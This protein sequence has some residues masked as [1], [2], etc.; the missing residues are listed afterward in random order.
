[1][2]DTK[3]IE[4]E[5]TSQMGRVSGK[6]VEDGADSF[7]FSAYLRGDSLAFDPVGYGRKDHYSPDTAVGYRLE[8]AGLNL[9][10]GTDSVYLAGNV[11][12]FSPQRGEPSKP[13]VLAL[14]R[15][16]VEAP[17]DTKFSFDRVYPN[18]FRDVL[19][20]QFSLGAG[21][22]VGMA[23]VSMT[24]QQVYLRP[25]QRLQPGSYAYR[26]QLPAGLAP[27]SYLLQVSVDGKLHSYKLLHM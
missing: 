23:V 26:L 24:G 10:Q 25:T 22:E 27:G 19:D 1:M 16:S 2:I 18:P 9:V 17:I 7:R 21:S 13:V 3:N 6:W 14:V 8:G 12:M 11:S 20:V 15:S 4:L 5:L